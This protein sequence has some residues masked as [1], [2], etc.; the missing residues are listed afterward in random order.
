MRDDLISFGRAMVRRKRPV[1]PPTAD[2]SWVAYAVD[3][4]DQ[5]AVGVGLD[6]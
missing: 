5:V 4:A 3:G 1:Q 2:E 6:R